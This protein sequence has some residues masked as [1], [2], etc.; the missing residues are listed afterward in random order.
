M[1][2]SSFLWRWIGSNPNLQWNKH[3]ENISSRRRDSSY[4]HK[5]RAHNLPLPITIQA[6]IQLH[7]HCN[8]HLLLYFQYSEFRLLSQSVFTALCK[9]M[10]KGWEMRW[11][12]LRSDSTDSQPWELE[13]YSPSQYHCMGVVRE[14]NHPSKGRH[15][16]LLLCSQKRLIQKSTSWRPLSKQSPLY[17]LNWIG[18]NHL[19]RG[20]GSRV[21]VHSGMHAW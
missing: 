15:I 12:V 11:L 7:F 20:G 10:I 2:F 21:F 18:C 14:S 13:L 3:F 8:A 1:M 4:K 5:E 6:K 9:H 19:Q 16:P 17:K